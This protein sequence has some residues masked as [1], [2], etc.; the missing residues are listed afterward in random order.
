[1]AKNLSTHYSVPDVKILVVDD[2]KL[3]LDQISEVLETM[4]YEVIKGK[5]GKE[6]I[7]MFE[8]NNPDLLLLDIRMLNAD[9]YEAY[10]EIKKNHKDAKIIFMS[11]FPIENESYEKIREYGMTY[12]LIKPFSIDVLK[13]AVKE[14]IGNS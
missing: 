9:G 8:K 4:G 7:K 10:F 6:A 3:V 2:E 13:D 11:A 1:M 5:D 12:L 14:V